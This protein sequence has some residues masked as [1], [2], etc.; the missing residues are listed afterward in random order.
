MDI[1][2]RP[3][4]LVGT[5]W[6]IVPW[7]VVLYVNSTVDYTQLHQ[8]DGHHRIFISK[9]TTEFHGKLRVLE[10]DWHSGSQAKF[11]CFFHR[12]DR[13]S[14]VGTYQAGTLKVS[15]G[16]PSLPTLTF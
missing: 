12:F 2:L 5:I 11:E 3:R 16:R 9:T 13:H 15:L 7:R 10:R 4:A 14:Q 6:V 8:M 1:A